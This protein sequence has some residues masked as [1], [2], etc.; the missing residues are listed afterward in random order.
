MER[1]ARLGLDGSGKTANENGESTTA[2]YEWEIQTMER[3]RTWKSR[4]EEQKQSRWETG[5]HHP[6]IGGKPSKSGVLTLRLYRRMWQ[7]LLD[8]VTILDVHTTEA[9][10]PNRDDGK[11]S[12][13]RP[14]FTVSKSTYSYQALKAAGARFR[15]AVNEFDKLGMAEGE[16]IVQLGNKKAK[17]DRVPSTPQRGE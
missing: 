9:K 8:E 15:P 17:K 16:V 4:G 11:V 12:M 5:R 10:P 2:W 6:S 14:V 7:Q 13:K 3:I 1:K